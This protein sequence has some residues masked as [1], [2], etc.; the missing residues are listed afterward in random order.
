M[1]NVILFDS[2]ITNEDADNSIQITIGYGSDGYLTE[3]YLTEDSRIFGKVCIDDVPFIVA[4]LR[5][6]ADAIE[7]KD[8][9]QT[10]G[11]GIPCLKKVN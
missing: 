10:I 5:D 9:Q 4:M 6:V 3:L 11:V 2:S 7:S 8:I 1:S